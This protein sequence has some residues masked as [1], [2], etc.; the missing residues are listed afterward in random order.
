MLQSV[1]WGDGRQALMCAV[2]GMPPLLSLK[3][4]DILSPAS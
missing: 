2:P 4:V 3:S 1:V